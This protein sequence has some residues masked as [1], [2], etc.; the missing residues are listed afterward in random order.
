M[1]STITQVERTYTARGDVRYRAVVNHPG[2]YKQQEIRDSDYHT[3]VHKANL[4][5]AQWN[6]IWAKRTAVENARSGRLAAALDK[7]QKQEEAKSRTVE[8]EQAWLRQAI[9][10]G[11]AGWKTDKLDATR[12]YAEDAG[13]RS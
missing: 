7:K 8:A 9:Y 3:V 1:N 6:E 11:G 5:A 10:D 4:K 2:L 12:R 13:V